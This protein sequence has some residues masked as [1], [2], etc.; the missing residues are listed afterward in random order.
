MTSSA[1][2][3]MLS[4]ESG[5]TFEHLCERLRSISADIASGSEIEQALREIPALVLL[6]QMP[7]L[8]SVKDRE[9]RFVFSN[10]AAC[11]A[12]GFDGC[13]ALSGK[14]VFQLFDEET[15]GILSAMDDEVFLGG[16]AVRNREERLAVGNGA[17][18]WFSVSKTALR[19][20]SGE[21]IGI[22]SISRDVT[23][24]RRQEELRHG[25]ARL[26]EMIA[27]GKP[28]NEILDSLIR[29]VET[30]LD[31]VRGSVL[32]LDEHGRRLGGGAAPSL[33]V[34]YA[35]QIDGIEVGPQCGSCG[36]AV[37]RG[38][39]VIVKDVLTD[40]LWSD[41][42]TLGTRFG[43]RSCWST[44]IIGSEQR[45][46]GTFALYSPTVREPTQ[47]ELELMTMATDLAGIALERAESERRIRQMAH[48]D[49]LTGLPNRALFWSQ[50]SR[51]LHEAKRES[52]KVTI[53]YLDLDNF[54]AIN[55]THG[56]AGGD[57]VLRV[58][59]ARMSRCIRASDLI[60]RLG[61]DEFAIVFSNP[62]HDESGVLRRL[63]KLRILL[64]EPVALDG[65]AVRATCSMGVAFFPSDGEEPEML[66]A[67]ADR[68]MYEAKGLG[69]NTLSVAAVDDS[70]TDNA[71]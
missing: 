7:D 20:R 62:S 42:R 49:A 30:Q 47:M 21:V 67:R 1:P 8:I 6:D 23:D 69:R 48:Y 12:A 5:K 13:A 29:L 3:G 52:R 61:G 37:W 35:R 16:S 50:F 26:L 39:A 9:G 19:D 54:K 33:P 45:I 51:A 41:F 31:D 65:D 38:S 17:N 10:I 25:H 70:L 44:P 64:A 66:L 59:A 34:A 71:A 36:T 32:V 40:P 24:R 2:N 11:A 43:F 53:A 14:T 56:H 46:L 27:R 55:D 58:L 18:S 63:E 4:D 68:A 22:V 60:V 57:E 15:A 28:L